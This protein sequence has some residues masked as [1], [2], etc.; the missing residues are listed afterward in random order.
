MKNELRFQPRY[1]VT[2]N[3][4]LW[5]R[6][7]V[8]KISQLKVQCFPFDVIVFAML[9]AHSIWRYSISFSMSCDH[10]LANEWAHCNGKNA[11]YIT[12]LIMPAQCIIG[13]RHF[14]RLHTDDFAPTTFGKTEANNYSINFTGCT[15]KE[16]IETPTN[17]YTHQDWQRERIVGGANCRTK[18]RFRVRK[19]CTTFKSEYVSSEARQKPVS[20]TGAHDLQSPLTSNGSIL[21][22]PKL[23]LATYKTNT[24]TY[25]KKKRRGLLFWIITK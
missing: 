1:H 5:S 11:S 23:H 24:H 8:I 7:T 25:V 16:S 19:N 22:K 21:T 9:S 12:I 14:S 20:K 13:N 18:A 6:A 4:T 10:E 3:C 15:S 2:F 17:L